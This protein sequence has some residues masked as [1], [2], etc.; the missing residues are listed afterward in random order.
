MQP[1]HIVQVQAHE[2]T[3]AKTGRSGSKLSLLQELRNG[4]PAVAAPLQP[5]D[6][7][8]APGLQGEALAHV[9]LPPGALQQMRLR[10]CV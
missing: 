8:P 10:R 1:L 9:Q 5:H 7:A 6:E 2:L 3:P 4:V